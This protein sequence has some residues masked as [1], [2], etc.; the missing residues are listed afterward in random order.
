MILWF[1]LPDAYKWENYEQNTFGFEF[2]DTQSFEL[3]F[4]IL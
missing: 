4:V 1:R 2:S 3:K